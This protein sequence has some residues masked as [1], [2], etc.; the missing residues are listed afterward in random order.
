[1][2]STPYDS[3]GW[4]DGQRDAERGASPRRRDGV[5]MSVMRIHDLAH[6]GQ[7]QARALWLGRKERT[8]NPLEIVG[9]N[10]GSVVPD[11]DN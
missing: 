5:D 10:A 11:F 6:D 9:R 8:E 4:H 7:T 2:N 3:H 1:M